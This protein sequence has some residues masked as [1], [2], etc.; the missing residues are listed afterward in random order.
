MSGLRISLEFITGR[1]VAATVLDR[2]EPEWPPHPGR[3]FMAL[4]AACFERGEDAGEVA[5]LEWIESLPAPDIYASDHHARSPAKFYVPVNDKITPTKAILQSTPG[6]ARSKQVRSYPTAIPLDSVMELV[7]SDAAG[8]EQNLDALSRVCA[9][10]IRVGHSSSL[11]RVWAELSIPH[12]DGEQ[13]QLR[14]RWQPAS[15]RSHWRARIAGAGEFNR[16][17]LA[18][19]ADRIERFASLKGRIESTK[20][21][22][23]REAKQAFESEFGEPFKKSLRAPEPTPP[24]LGLWQGYLPADEFDDEP[25][26]VAGQHFESDL[27]ILAKQEGRNISISDCAALTSRLRDAAMSCCPEDPVPAWLG[28]H[29]PETRQPT[30]LPHTAFVALPFVGREY[31]DGH[32]MGLALALPRR[33]PPES[34]GPLLGP[35]LFDDQGETRNVELKLGRFGTWTL[36]LEDRA[37]P[38]RTL[39]N[40]TWT[41]PGTIWASVTPVVLDKFPRCSRSE[42]RADWEAE[43][44]GII[45]DS[46]PRAGLP[47]PVQI[48]IDTTSWHIGSPR[49]F[50]KSRTLRGNAPGD[51]RTPLGDGFPA[52]PARPGKPARPQIHVC[53]RFGVPV[54]GPVLIGAGRFLGYGMCKPLPRW[55]TP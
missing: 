11:V 36:R 25:A 15:G 17:R 8:A 4:A 41:G 7:W 34:R 37:E 1:C 38:P 47:K 24:T 12:S 50:P 19:K 13:T 35:M 27:L 53:L 28:G 20:G 55:R 6:L 30:D 43:V 3:I 54:C 29:D 33:I 10:V 40:P 49:A 22:T 31:A 23:Q 46:C 18:C 9:N 39:Q 14:R 16:L 42:R 2:D 51:G 26:S 48:D 5:A 21:Q 52:L 32:I 45:A 44:R